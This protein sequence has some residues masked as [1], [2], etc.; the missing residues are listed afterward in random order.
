M[1]EALDKREKE[2]YGEKKIDDERRCGEELE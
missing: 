2:K 1:K